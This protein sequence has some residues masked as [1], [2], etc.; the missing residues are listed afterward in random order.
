MAKFFK[1]LKSLL[2]GAAD[3]KKKKIVRVT[4]LLVLT[5][6]SALLLFLMD[7]Y[8]YL[9]LPFLGGKDFN[10]FSNFNA[11]KRG[12]VVVING[13][14][15]TKESFAF[16]VWNPN[17]ITPYADF[18]T[19][20]ITDFLYNKCGMKC[21]NV[22]FS[23]WAIMISVFVVLWSITIYS[24]FEGKVKAKLGIASPE[25]AQEKLKSKKY[26][27][28]KILGIILVWVLCFALI[29]TI[30][31]KSDNFDI[32]GKIF[33]N[34][35]QTMLMSV[36]LLLSLPLILIIFALILGLIIAL[37]TFIAEMITKKVLANKDVQ[38]ILDTAK[39]NSNN[40]LK[41]SETGDGANGG[42]G[43][44]LGALGE[45]SYD[46]SLAKIFPSLK[47]IDEK[48]EDEQ[49]IPQLEDVDITLPE[50]ALRFRAYMCERNLYF[51]ERTI[52]NFIGALAVSRLMILEGLSGTGKSTLPRLFSDFVG[53]KVFYAPVQAT[54]R[55][56][57]DLVGYYS[58]F[59]NEYKETD[60][61]KRLY[62]ASFREK[63]INMMVLDEMNISR[64]EYY[65]ADFLS[66]LEYPSQD[67]LIKVMQIKDGQAQPKNFV[68]G[69]V[70][71]P[72]NTWF[73]GTANTDDST[74]TITDKVYDRAIVLDFLRIND[75]FENNY[76]SEEVH[77]SSE[78]L[79]KLFD[80]A[81]ANESYRLNKE[82]KEK[83]R[84]L[85]DFV[86]ETFNVTFGNRIMNQIENF[87]PVYVA[88][89]GTK[90]E[91]LDFIF[92][93]KVIRKLQGKYDEYV[94][95]GLTKMVRF[96]NSLYGKDQLPYT[97]E[98]IVELRKK[99]I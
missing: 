9:R 67:W 41:V 44:G 53:N 33:L 30:S 76:N 72:L 75:P 20:F 21:F 54:W 73:I 50:L 18:D 68:D 63:E 94:K 89:G 45:E 96:I 65:F 14:L 17:D 24:L 56:R 34:L 4:I 40:P 71:I 66:I 95:D 42:S 38:Q 98:A 35:V 43:A 6:W 64:I 13:S 2:F 57:T 49:N 16:L 90:N 46:L 79:L 85:C 59:T 58:E 37:L 80:Q 83:F 60:F 99:L 8:N 81:K 7:S 19:N 91:A 5:I 10:A 93:R 28:F 3:T 52:R 25:T 62:E 48:Y 32:N 36:G 23:S 47:R 97:E 27:L 12:E 22:S 61:L 84:K 69:N 29:L 55:D 87:V 31:S 74:F 82:D 39:A 88:L 15:K 86:L 92:S 11:L 70:R 51:D 26:F 78:Q 1:K 77:I